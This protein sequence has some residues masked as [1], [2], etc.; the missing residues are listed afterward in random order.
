M[1]LF[2]VIAETP[3]AAAAVSAVNVETRGAGAKPAL[4]ACSGEAMCVLPS[5][6]GVMGFIAKLGMPGSSITWA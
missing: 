3:R 1:A 5:L 2:M 6:M 4:T